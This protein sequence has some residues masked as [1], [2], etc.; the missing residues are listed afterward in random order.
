MHADLAA[1][2]G[3][4]CL[5]IF[6]SSTDSIELVLNAENDRHEILQLRLTA[7]CTRDRRLGQSADGLLMRVGPRCLQS[8]HAGGCL[9]HPRDDLTRQLGPNRQSGD[10]GSNEI[11][12]CVQILVLPL[13]FQLQLLGLHKLEMLPSELFIQL[14]HLLCHNHWA[15][16][17]LLAL[18]LPIDVCRDA[19]VHPF[20]LSRD[21]MSASRGVQRCFVQSHDLHLVPEQLVLATPLDHHGLGD[22]DLQRL[23]LGLLRNNLCSHVSHLLLKPGTLWANPDYLRQ[24]LGWR[25]S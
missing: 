2:R 25:L 7:C 1:V 9:L 13:E 17:Q 5:V 20:H 14:G 10:D 12:I 16:L 11:L 23:Q 8:S 24:L 4:Q 22:L 15:P 3:C 6:K 19:S 18:H 21:I